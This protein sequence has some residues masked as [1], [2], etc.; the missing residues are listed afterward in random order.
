MSKNSNH[1][2]DETTDDEY[3]YEEEEEKPKPK[4]KKQKAASKTKLK[5][6]RP[7]SS[8]QHRQVHST[9]DLLAFQQPQMFYGHQPYMQSPPMFPMYPMQQMQSMQQPFQA[10][11]QSL[12]LE[13]LGDILKRTIE[14]KLQ[15]LGISNGSYSIEP[16]SQE[17]KTLKKLIITCTVKEFK[18]K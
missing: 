8:S 17:T 15:E 11:H 13:T 16:I 18:S 2:Q 9:N 14:V 1:D 7:I 10:Q 4:R 5:R 3:S 12:K 6:N